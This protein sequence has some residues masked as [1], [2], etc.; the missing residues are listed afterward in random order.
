L[1]RRLDDEKSSGGKPTSGFWHSI[2][3][4]QFKSLLLPDG[5]IDFRKR[6][7]ENRIFVIASEAKQSKI[8]RF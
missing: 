2:V 5:N 6:S 8:A 4:R 7:R 3:E 1:T